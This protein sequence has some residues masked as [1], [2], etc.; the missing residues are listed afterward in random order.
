MSSLIFS[1][2]SNSN[3]FSNALFSNSLNISLSS[4]NIYSLVPE[5]ISA[6]TN[7]LNEENINLFIIN[8]LST[9]FQFFSSR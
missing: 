5:L 9:F 7:L 8:N 3:I 4:D 6:K 1:G 2:H